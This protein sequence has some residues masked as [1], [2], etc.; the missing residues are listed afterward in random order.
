M[1]TLRIEHPVPDFDARKKAFDADP[2]GRQAGGVRT[3]RVLRPVDDRNF[4]IVDLEFDDVAMAQAFLEKLKAVWQGAEG[5]VMNAP[6]ARITETV[7]R[8]HY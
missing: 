2:A 6:R 3:Y 8:V 5:K 7:Q 4:A 1:I